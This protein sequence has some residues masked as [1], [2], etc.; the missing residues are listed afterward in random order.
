MAQSNSRGDGC[1]VL[2]IR[3]VCVQTRIKMKDKWISFG[4]DPDTVT[5]SPPELVNREFDTL[6]IGTGF[7]AL[8]RDPRY[9]YHFF[10]KISPTEGLI[11]NRLFRITIFSKWVQV[12]V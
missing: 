10:T 12:Y 5:G 2:L 1:Y 11:E 8:T 4:C 3:Y 9:G 7:Y 6:P